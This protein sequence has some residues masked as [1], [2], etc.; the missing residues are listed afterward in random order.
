MLDQVKQILEKQNLNWKII[1]G[2]KSSSFGDEFVI[3]DAGTLHFLI[4]KDRGTI[5]ILIGYPDTT[6][7]KSYWD[8][9]ASLDDFPDSL[10]EIE[11]ENNY[12]GFD[13]IVEMLKLDFNP[14]SDLET[15]INFLSSNINQIKAAFSAEN[16]EKTEETL[17]A[18]MQK[19][20][21][22]F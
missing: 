16:S 6:W 13:Y 21:K 17:K 22:N 12:W 10:D 20:I 14:Y 7:G 9:I 18:I 19:R 1:E 2:E 5:F 8:K 4:S 3:V 11:E 15:H